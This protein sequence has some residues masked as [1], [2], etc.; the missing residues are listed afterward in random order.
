MKVGLRRW[1]DDTP[2]RRVEFS[3]GFGSNAIGRREAWGFDMGR[4]E[5]MSSIHDLD[6]GIGGTVY[7][8][9]H[10]PLVSHLGNVVNDSHSFYPQLELLHPLLQK[11]INYQLELERATCLKSV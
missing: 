2:K 1:F 4:S 7:L 9:R 5:F 6:I 11:L 10:L 8:F 3:F